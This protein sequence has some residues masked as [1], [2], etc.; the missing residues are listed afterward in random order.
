METASA[1]AAVAAMSTST[2]ATMSNYQYS[3]TNA[4]NNET[5]TIPAPPSGYLY[6]NL[7]ADS[8]FSGVKVTTEY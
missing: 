3:S 5:L 8:S 7:Y 4:G 1:A 6:V 2:W